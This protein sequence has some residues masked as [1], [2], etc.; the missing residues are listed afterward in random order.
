MMLLDRERNFPFNGALKLNAKSLWVVFINTCNESSRWFVDIRDEGV[1]ERKV[2]GKEG[3]E[4]RK[5]IR[6]VVD[7]IALELV[8]ALRVNSDLYP[9]KM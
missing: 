8:S 4:F 6:S 7:F 9:G 3:G 5:Q 1:T 2:E